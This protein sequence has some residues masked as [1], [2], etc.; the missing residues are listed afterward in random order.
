M[1]VTYSSVQSQPS[2]DRVSKTTKT[3]LVCCLL[4]FCVVDNAN[5]IYI[6]VL[7]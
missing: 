3:L 6:N 2:V 4:Y 5:Y 1:L 7:I